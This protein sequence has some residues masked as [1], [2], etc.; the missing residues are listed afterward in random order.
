[1]SYTS[2]Q[3]INSLKTVYFLGGTN[4]TFRFNFKNQAG[5][6]VD[7]NN[8]ELT[9]LICEYGNFENVL[10]TKTGSL[11]DPYSYKVYLGA[12]D[13]VGWDGVYSY[14]IRVVLADEQVIKPGQGIVYISGG[15]ES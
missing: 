1:M 5:N 14:Q 2:Y 11:I 7:M 13:S 15:M 6:S 4:F 3:E 9:L 8:T 10:L 12:Q